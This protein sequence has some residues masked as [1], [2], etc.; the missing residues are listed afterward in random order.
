MNRSLRFF[1]GVG[2]LA[3]LVPAMAVVLPNRFTGFIPW[4]SGASTVS[5][6]VPALAAVDTPSSQVTPPT[7]EVDLSTEAF[8][9]PSTEESN[10]SM[11]TA[12]NDH[13]S[14]HHSSVS[15]DGNSNSGSQDPTPTTGTPNPPKST[16]TSTS[17]GNT[18]GTITGQACPCTVT[19]TAELK[20]NVSLQGDLIV[21]GGTL[22]ARP[23]VNVNGN[24]FQIMFMKG[25]KADFQGSKVFTWSDRGVKQNLQRD[26]VFRN[27]KRIMW[28]S[29]G[30][31]STL[32]YLTVADSGTSS[33][34]DYPL[35]WHLNGNST[36][37]TIVEG[38][39]VTNGKNHAYVPHGSHGITFRDVIAKNTK[40][41]A[42]W[43]DDPG[44]NESCS[45]QKFCTV[46]NSNDIV[47]DH[48]LVDGVTNGPG[49]S[50][51]FTL[52]AFNLGAGSG[53]VVKNSVAIN[54]NPSHVKDCSGFKW[55][56]DANQ[57]E[58]GNVWVFQNNYSF[59]GKSGPSASGGPDACHGIFVWQNDGNHHIINGFTGGGIDHG[60]YK[61]RYEYR[62]VNV[63]Y[64]EVHARGVVFN[65]GNVEE[66]L[67]AKH[68]AAGSADNPTA[69]FTKTAIDRFTL[70]NGKGE[71]G[72]YVFNNTGLTCSDIVEE[73]VA[74]GTVVVID[75]D[76][77]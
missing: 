7:N 69:V 22:V 38:V 54:V 26:V 6:P 36:R 37:G 21:E 70:R 58:G 61:N 33:L 17:S 66:V 52:A 18:S 51:G 39:V 35:H 56:S 23:G 77:C 46:D 5:G 68:Q 48:V 24:G 32:K 27:M 67:A 14:D 9:S 41:P 29:G 45:F 20:G 73:S 64:M 28:M 11:T 34:G 76:K 31:A 53:N 65:G 62:N 8:A 30:G 74:S 44:T 43:W 15:N 55:P 2:I 40:G 72:Y 75:G 12:G 50:R 4:N 42:L 57:N 60:A 25:G 71:P 10:D 13:S 47:Y 59:S 3:I 16:T 49:D 63:P 1:L 19:G